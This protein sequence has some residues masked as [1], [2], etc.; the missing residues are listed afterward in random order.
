MLNPIEKF[1][2]SRDCYKIDARNALAVYYM[3]IMIPKL[4]NFAAQY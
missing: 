2:H 3:K 1:K 4:L